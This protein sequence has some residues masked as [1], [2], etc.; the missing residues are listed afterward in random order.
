MTG[1]VRKATLI[2]AVGLLAGTAAMAG[3]PS[4]TTSTQPTGIALVGQTAGTPDGTSF[5][6]AAY[7]IRDASSNPVPGSTVIMNFAACTDVKLCSIT[8][9]VSMS[10]N[11]AAKTVTGVTD[12]AGLVTFRVVGGGNLAGV[13][14]TA[15][16]V[17]VTADGVP[18]NTV[19]AATFDMNGSSG[20]TLGDITLAKND[21]TFNPT[22]TRSDFNKNGAVTLAD[23]TVI[24]VVFSAGGS[25]ASCGT[26]CP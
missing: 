21:F 9:P 1:L 13:H 16:C 23:I 17:S 24:K 8:Q 14:T 25:A 26:Y 20:V 7:T 3:V 6:A 22:F 12:A 15:P 19:R 5:G 10:V 2:T 4:A 11:C 18:L